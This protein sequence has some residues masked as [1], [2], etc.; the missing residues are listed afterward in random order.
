MEQ[1]ILA[2]GSAIPSIGFGTYKTSKGDDFSV[3]R[4]AL[5]C[6]YRHLDTAAFYGNEEVIAAAIKEKGI[7]REDLF[8]ATKVW[9]S[10]MGYEKTRKAFALSAKK[11]DTEYIDLYLIHW[12]RPDLSNEE[13][14]PLLLDTWRSME[15]LYREG[16]AKAIG[17]CNFL[18][19]HMMCL[20]ENCTIR[21]MVNQIEFHP[22]YIQNI[23]VEFCH[24]EG[25]L[26]EAW[27]PIGRA[28]VLLE[29]VLMEMAG[30]Y[31]KSVAQLCIRFA[32]Q[33]GVLPLPKSSAPERMKENL[34][35]FDFE[36]S[37]E[38]MSVLMTLPQ[39]GWSG[40]HPDRERVR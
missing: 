34:D 39:L 15:T 9:K 40:E 3:L 12:P 33:C 11:L 37:F 24:A 26:V 21:P 31:G 28:R 10:D 2:N 4:N 1:F 14:K 6:G 8:L 22:G 32:L 30:R 36:I 25:I 19:H 20:L 35:V 38:D 17:V 16:K 5:E 29:P 7:A 13:W 23:A 27:S 18:P